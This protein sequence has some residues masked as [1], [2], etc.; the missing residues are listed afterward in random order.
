M[1]DIS[2]NSIEF[3]LKS[4][5]SGVVA[6]S[7]DKNGA[8]SVSAKCILVVVGSPYSVSNFA[9]Q[10][11]NQVGWHKQRKQKRSDTQTRNVLTLVG[12]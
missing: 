7:A 10:G 8:I 4:L 6:Q 9:K 12:R 5:F 11:P 2:E 1:H 3:S